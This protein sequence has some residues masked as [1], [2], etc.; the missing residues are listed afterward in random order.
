MTLSPSA[1][2]W[3]AK[4][5]IKLLL[6][7]IPVNY[8]IWRKLGIFKH[9]TMTQPEYAFGV[10]KTHF[11]RAF[12]NRT[13]FKANFAA[14][15][16]GP[17]DSL[18]SA[19]IAR[20]FGFSRTYL[21]DSDAFASRELEHYRRMAD[22]LLERGLPA[23]MSAEPATIEA[24][25]SEVNAIYLTNGLQSLKSLP[26]SS[27]DFVWS[28]AVLEHIRLSEFLDT[29]KELR[30]ILTAEGIASHRV[31]LMDHL[32]GALNNLRF[33]QGVWESEIM[34]GSGFYT[35][36]IR[37]GTMLRLFEEAGFAPEVVQVTRWDE[38]PTPPHKIAPMFRNIPSE[39]LRIKAFDVI[40]RPAKH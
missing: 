38:I 6:S 16:I 18:F 19:L 39:E 27:V 21:I 5:A 35:N 9:G 28:Q 22:F 23:A 15:E 10:F 7:R 14:L 26:N 37:Y 17:G 1:I 32:A 29:M 13:S 30:R 4:I 8:R 24:M 40:L 36:R 25:L 31:D 33:S 12:P 20:S 3:Q 2:P 11:E 34:A